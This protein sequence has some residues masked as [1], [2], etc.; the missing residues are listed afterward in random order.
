MVAAI[1]ASEARVIAVLSTLTQGASLHYGD[2]ARAERDTPARKHTTPKRAGR[3]ARVSEA[4]TA[5]PTPDST[6]LTSPSVCTS[7]PGALSEPR[8]PED[9]SRAESEVS[10]LDVP[11]AL[12]AGDVT[13]NAAPPITEDED[14]TVSTEVGSMVVLNFGEA[15]Y[16]GAHSAQAGEVTSAGAHSA[17]EGEMKRAGADSTLAGDMKRAGARAAQAGEVKHS[18]ESGVEAA[19]DDAA[20]VEVGITHEGGFMHAPNFDDEQHAGSDP[21]DESERSFTDESERSFTDAEATRSFTGEESTCV[22]LRSSPAPLGALHP[23]PPARGFGGNFGGPRAGFCG[24]SRGCGASEWGWVWVEG[25]QLYGPG[26]V[27]VCLSERPSVDTHT[28]WPVWVEDAEIFGS[29]T[30]VLM[31][32]TWETRL[33]LETR[34]VLAWDDGCEVVRRITIIAPLMA[35]VERAAEMR[36]AGMKPESAWDRRRPFPKTRVFRKQ[37]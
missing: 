26:D 25:A 8:L 13:I 35:A 34:R 15:K 20:A 28:V 19:D 7:P 27:E 16:A 3:R 23:S 5:A 29:S 32:D 36:R 24:V 9:E 14:A 4:T 21:D 2:S 30:V 37:N 10:A 22:E 1:E 12:I 6:A 11:I 31:A 18:D 17:Q 33:Q